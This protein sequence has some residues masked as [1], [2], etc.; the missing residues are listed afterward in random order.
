MG[1]AVSF[2]APFWRRLEGHQRDI[3]MADDSQQDK[4]RIGWKYWKARDILELWGETEEGEKKRI[5]I[6][7]TM[8]R[9]LTNDVAFEDLPSHKRNYV[10]TELYLRPKAY[11]GKIVSA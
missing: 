4:Q 8:V 10:L 6:P 9:Q 11:G 2:G 7:G 3:G 1:R 5:Q